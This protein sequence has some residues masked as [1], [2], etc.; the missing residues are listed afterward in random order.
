MV[1]N[2]TVSR[3]KLLR[4]ALIVISS[5]RGGKGTMHRLKLYLDTSAI[6]LLFQDHGSERH[7]VT[8]DFFRN[9][10]E[11][12]VHDVFISSVV[13][14]ELNRTPDEERRLE[15][16]KAVRRLGLTLLEFDLED[17]A[18]YRLAELYSELR[19]V[20][21]SKREDALHLAI[22]TIHEMDMLVTW[23]YRHLAGIE[24][25]ARVARANVSEGFTKPL[26][27]I[28]PLEVAYP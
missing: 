4:T 1:N 28:T 5:P 16:L 20:P 9:I 8:C 27:L 2:D 23:N 14:D 25:E 10:V 15:M 22:A 12:G 26:R 7:E 13:L 21:V 19:I 6:S 17:D 3:D 24:R 11:G 18:I